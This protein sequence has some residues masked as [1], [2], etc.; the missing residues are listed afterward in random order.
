MGASNGIGYLHLLRTR[1]AFRNLWLGEVVSLAGDWFT[2]IALYSLL[3][4]RTG[5][6]ES[7]GLM[8]AL[9]F[10]PAAIFG[11]VAGLVA[12]RLPRKWILVGCDLLRAA[13]VM[14]F[15]LV[16]ASSHL[17][18]VYA[19]VFLQMT[20]TS[21]FEPAEQA[22]IASVVPRGELVAANTLVGATWSAMLSVGAV[23]G[24]VVVAAVGRDAAFAIDAGSYL[25]SA[26]L[27]SRAAL[28]KRPAA[29]ARA[30]GLLRRTVGDLL[31]GLK[32]F[33]SHA[34]VRR[35][36]GVKSGWALAGGGAILLYAVLGD[37]EFP[38]AGSGTAGIGV[39]LATRG[40]G[41]LVGPLAARRLG[42]DDPAWLERAITISWAISAV[43][44]VLFAF[45]PNLPVAALMLCLAHTGISTQWTFSSSL[46]GLSVPDELRGR[47]FALDSMLFMLAMAASSYAT[48]VALD[49]LGVGPRVLMAGLGA[50]LLLPAAV[51]LLTHRAAQRSIDLRP[52]PAQVPS[53]DSAGGAAA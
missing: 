48:G 6:G 42:G 39:L 30:G 1:P 9:R 53:H 45:S 38:I 43:F 8:L 35:I 13:T 16:S 34:R 10:L 2:L 29:A 11:P 17:W 19:L 26:F 33:A 31:L 22:S 5:K 49:R 20:L 21:F 25:L 18:L 15:P 27:V 7:V 24:G 52:G 46:I 23:A 3:L 40:I 28:P 41:A 36:V 50:V 32:L 47:V 51:W 12:D 4:E 44:Y 14:C 37:R